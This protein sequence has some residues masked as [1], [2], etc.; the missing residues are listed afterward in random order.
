L[1]KVEIKSIKLADN[2]INI[3]NNKFFMNKLN[4]KIA[5]NYLIIVDQITKKKRS[6]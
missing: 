2:K 5:S 4:I 6:D 1:E 3:N